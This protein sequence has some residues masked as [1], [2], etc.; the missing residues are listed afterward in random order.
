MVPP[1]NLVTGSNGTTYNVYATYTGAAPGDYGVGLS[2]LPAGGLTTTNTAVTP[3]TGSGD[4]TQNF[5][6]V[7]VD[8]AND[9]NV[10]V[11]WTDPTSSSWNVN[12]ASSSDGG[13]TWS[14]PVT[15]GHGTY[16][17]ITADAAGK[18]DVAWYSAEQTSG[19]TGDPN[20]APSGTNWTVDF[21][22]ST[23]A[24][25]GAPTFAAETTGVGTVKSG[26]ICTQGTN[27]SGDR[28]SAM[29]R[30]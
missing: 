30:K 2:A 12:F 20:L 11:V 8:N 28:R 29:P 9:N 4:T 23:N 18:V 5:P 24:L 27:C 13:K 1:G 10:Y 19:Y 14:A 16:P 22:Q 3:A 21:A 15:V 26:A 25:S 17:W 6:V 7:A